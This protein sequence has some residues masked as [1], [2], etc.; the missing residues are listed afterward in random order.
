MQIIRHTKIAQN[1]KIWVELVPSD[2]TKERFLTDTAANHQGAIET[3]W[4][5]VSGSP[6]TFIF[7]HRPNTRNKMILTKPQWK[8]VWAGCCLVA[9]LFLHQENRTEPPFPAIILLFA[10]W[11]VLHP[12]VIMSACVCVRVWGGPSSLSVAVRHEHGSSSMLPQRSFTEAQSTS[13]WARRSF[14][15]FCLCQRSDW[16][17]PPQTVSVAIKKIS[18]YDPKYVKVHI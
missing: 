9:A 6:L 10:H 13:G 1:I 15:P 8:C 18:K 16:A 11:T 4:C 3:L 12:V 17:P 2:N 7:T 14:P 5:H